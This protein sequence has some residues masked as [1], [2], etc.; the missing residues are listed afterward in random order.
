MD[1]IPT[2]HDYNICFSTPEGR[3]VLANMMAEGNF[4]RVI[5]TPEETAVENFIKIVLS[6]TGLYPS[7]QKDKQGRI[8]TYVNNLF[9]NKMEY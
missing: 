8:D 9:N 2:E 4:F 5:K 7:D 1:R 3:R 6:K